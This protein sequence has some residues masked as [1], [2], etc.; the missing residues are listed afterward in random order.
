MKESKIIRFYIA[1]HKQ[2]WEYLLF[3]YS[4]VKFYTSYIQEG[5]CLLMTR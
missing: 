4:G 5:Q 1:Q 2:N 3:D